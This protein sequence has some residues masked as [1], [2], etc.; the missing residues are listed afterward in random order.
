MDDIFSF[1]G[2]CF[3]DPPTGRF[4]KS[5]RPLGIGHLRGPGERLMGPGR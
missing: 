1:Q 5:L 3:S 4:W 2:L